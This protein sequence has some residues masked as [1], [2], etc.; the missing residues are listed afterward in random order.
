[1]GPT[2]QKPAGKLHIIGSGCR[3]RFHATVPFLSRH[4]PLK[5]LLV[6][7]FKAKVIAVCAILPEKLELTG[8]TVAADKP[9]A[10][11]REDAYAFNYLAQMATTQFG[12]VAGL[13]QNRGASIMHRLVHD[14]SNF[15]SAHPVALMSPVFTSKTTEIAVFATVGRNGDHAADIDGIPHVVIAHLVRNFKQAQNIIS[16]Q[17]EQ[18]HDLI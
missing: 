5:C 7:S 8:R 18:V 14:I 9:D 12:V 1:M 4:I 13:K 3:E 6:R 10:D 15:A 11:V 17:T 16:A 2:N